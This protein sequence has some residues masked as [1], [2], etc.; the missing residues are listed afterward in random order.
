MLIVCA[1]FLRLHRKKEDGRR[2]DIDCGL[3]SCVVHWCDI[4][5][6]GRKLR[7]KKN[8]YYDLNIHHWAL[9]CAVH[10][11]S[12]C[13]FVFSLIRNVSK[14]QQSFTFIQNTTCTIDR[15]I[16]FCVHILKDF[17]IR[18]TDK[19]LRYLGLILHLRGKIGKE[20]VQ[21]LNYEFN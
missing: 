21:V 19:A 15:K 20:K 9:L 6:H 16:S 14:W 3:R 1:V 4:L 11:H 5:L 8:S 18:E 17:C 7:L 2:C 10:S 13:I 12:L